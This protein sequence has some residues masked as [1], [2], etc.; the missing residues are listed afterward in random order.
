MPI[1]TAV[2]LGGTAIT[3]G[4]GGVV[5]TAIASIVVGILRFGLQMA[6]VPTQYLDIPVGLLLVIAVAVRGIMS[7][8]KKPAFLCRTKSKENVKA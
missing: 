6:K 5:G 8:A 1:I 4:S 3:G 7:Y 2:V